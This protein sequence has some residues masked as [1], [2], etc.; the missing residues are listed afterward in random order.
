MTTRL[1]T[2]SVPGRIQ[3]PRG[4]RTS[5]RKDDQR[6]DSPVRA[7]CGDGYLADPG[8]D[9]GKQRA[10]PAGADLVHEPIEPGKTDAA[11]LRGTGARVAGP[12]LERRTGRSRT[13]PFAVL[14]PGTARTRRRVGIEPPSRAAG[15][16]RARCR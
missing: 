10:S 6:A 5:D 12:A 8:P 11:G 15:R 3:D 9:A 7:H 16:S 14:S 1:S 13:G 4:E 2:S